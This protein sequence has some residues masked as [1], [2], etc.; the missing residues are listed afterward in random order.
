MNH[1]RMRI[2]A[3]LWEVQTH[4][5]YPTMTYEVRARTFAIGQELKEYLFCRQAL[6]TKSFFT[7]SVRV[8]K[9]NILYYASLSLL[10]SLHACV[11]VSR[12]RHSNLIARHQAL[13]HRAPERDRGQQGMG[14]GSRK[15]RC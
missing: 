3:Y 2:I 12:G 9:Y 6:G 1:Q 13:G 11:T 5:L 4:F 14:H 15:H 7:N 8:W 10:L